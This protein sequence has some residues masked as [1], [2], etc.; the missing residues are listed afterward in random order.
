MFLPGDHRVARGHAGGHD[1]LVERGQVGRMGRR[2]QVQMHAGGLDAPRQ[3]A[4]HL[5]KLFLARHHLGHV[6]LAADLRR[7]IEQVHLVPALGQ[8]RGGRQAGRAGAHHGHA[9]ARSTRAGT[10][11]RSHG[12]RAG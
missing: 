5:V 1:D 3:V 9:A 10:P 7:G 4:Q 2:V 11:A 8:Q 6:E 12:R